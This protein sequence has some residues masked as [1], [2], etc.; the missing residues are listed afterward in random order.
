VR[1]SRSASAERVTCARLGACALLSFALAC[2]IPAGESGSWE[3]RLGRD[4]PRVGRIYDTHARAYVERDVLLQRAHLADFV[5][6]GEKHDNADHHR[7]QAEVIQFLARE[8]A[9]PTLAVEML[10]EDDRP[11][12]DAW[13]A[14]QPENVDALGE[15]VE[16]D[17]S[18]WPPWKIYRPVFAAAVAHQLPIEPA[19]LTRADMAHL[20]ATGIS[21]IAPDRAR[22]LALD[23]PL[24]A[25]Q[26]ESLAAEVREGHCGMVEESSVREMVDVQRVR[27]ATLADALLRRGVPGVL[28]A[29]AGHVRK[30]RAVPL[31]LARRAPE[32]HVVSVAFLEVS[33]NGAA[34]D[35][36]ELERAYDFVW[37]TPRV[38]DLDPCE[39]FREQLQKLRQKPPGRTAGF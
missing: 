24:T 39:K 20:H 10:D 6:L 13:R 28:I 22:R 16:W 27:D 23:P 2:A 31:Y 29:G 4:D 12:L 25:A 5:L 8:G 3:S 33:K 11:K 17:A 36:A 18:G 32:R 21:G 19:N 7:L 9:P 26:R 37:Y 30:D 14:T 15:M 35:P 38:D 34:D 1:T